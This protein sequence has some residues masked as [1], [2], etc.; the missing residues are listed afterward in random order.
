M[1]KK[2][3]TKNKPK[4]KKSAPRKTVKKSVKKKKALKKKAV[5]KTA[6]R[7]IPTLKKKIPIPGSERSALLG[8]R[9][10]GPA[11]P[12]ERILV[13]VLVRRRSSSQGLTSM[14]EEM[15]TRKPLERKH[16]SREEFAASHGADPDDLE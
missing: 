11:D 16:L 6:K 9:V 12:S 13:T 4:A 10:V 7:T 5:K 3:R 2:P 15:G 14:I 1:P 8:A